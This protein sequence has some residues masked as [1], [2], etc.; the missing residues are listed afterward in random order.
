MFAF[1]M[2]NFTLQLHSYLQIFKVYKDALN[3][4]IVLTHCCYYQLQDQFQILAPD[5]THGY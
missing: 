3:D 4:P 1:A 2:P 5:P